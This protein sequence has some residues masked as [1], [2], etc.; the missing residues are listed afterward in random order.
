MCQPLSNECVEN[1]DLNSFSTETL[2]CPVCGTSYQKNKTGRTREYCSTTCQEF[3][4]FKSAMEE[5]MTKINFN[6][7]SA[8]LMKREFWILAQRVQVP[9]SDRKNK[10]VKK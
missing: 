6:G 10:K 4:K 7:S 5:R 1:N 9:Y 8:R 3:N 2:V